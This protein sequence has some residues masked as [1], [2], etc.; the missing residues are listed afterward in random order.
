[1]ICKVPPEST[2]DM[3]N[4]L[5]IISTGELES[6]TWTPKEKLPFC[7]GVPEMVPPAESVSPSG[8]APE[9][10][11]QLYGAVPPVA[12]RVAL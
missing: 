6:W 2:T 7:D 1:V 3:L 10:N 8:K 11:V 5:A 12:E 4:V 9:A